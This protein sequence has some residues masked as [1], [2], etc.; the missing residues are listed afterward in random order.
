MSD[1]T[2]SP[3]M[4]HQVFPMTRD[5]HEEFFRYIWEATADAGTAEEYVG[6][7]NYPHIREILDL[8][9]AK[10]RLFAAQFSRDYPDA[11]DESPYHEFGYHDEEDEDEVWN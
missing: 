11:I 6:N 2:Y 9:H 10:G 1:L 8:L 4:A 3:K 7:R 5:D